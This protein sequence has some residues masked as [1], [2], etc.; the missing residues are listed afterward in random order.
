MTKLTDS[1]N[2][3][4]LCFDDNG[5]NTVQVTLYGDANNVILSEPM[6]WDDISN[7]IP[8]IISSTD[9]PAKLASRN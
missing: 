2:E 8:E 9:K 1:Q 5:N 4:T 6:N 7:V 3:L